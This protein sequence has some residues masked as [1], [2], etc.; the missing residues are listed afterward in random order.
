MTLLNA[1]LQ[2]R[3]VS[4]NESADDASTLADLACG[5]CSIITGLSA[6]APAE[7]ARRLF[8]L[9]FVPGARIESIRK[10][11]LADPMIFAV[12]GYEIALRRAQ[13]RFIH[14]GEAA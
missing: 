6:G 9:G 4:A 5:R 1:R 11:P 8:D 14:I 2:E 12:A 7:V 13:A 10:A 3:S